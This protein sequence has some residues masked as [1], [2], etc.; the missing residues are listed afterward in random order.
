MI[1]P[2]WKRSADG[3]GVGN[4]GP[5][6]PLLAGRDLLARHE[7]RLAA[8]RRE[9]GVPA[10]HWATLYRALFEAFALYVQSLPVAT[11][12]T[13]LAA[14]L[15]AVIRS[16]ALRRACLLP[17]GAVAEEIAERQDVWTYVVASGALLRD[18]GRDVLASRVELFDGRDR[19]IGEWDPWNGPPPLASAAYARIASRAADPPRLA[20]LLSV[21]V[22]SSIVPP[23]GM[24]WITADAAALDGWLRAIAGAGAD[25]VDPLGH[26]FAP[27]PARGR[28][29]AATPVRSGPAVASP[30]TPDLGA[31]ADQLVAGLRDPRRSPAVA[32]ASTNSPFLEWLCEGLASGR[33]P[34]HGPEA[35]VHAVPDGWL[36]VAPAAFRAFAGHDACATAQKAFLRLHVHRKSPGGHHLW[37]WRHTTRDGVSRR[38]QGF[39]VPPLPGMPALAAH[40][41]EPG[42]VSLD[43]PLETVGTASD[44][45]E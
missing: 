7:E 34:T 13:L 29:D 45:V 27:V 6:M 19:P 22:A 1:T 3:S 30:A 25:P 33:V 26:L 42:L 36:I 23:P 15:D 5:R 2:W 14:R 21:L 40:D 18:L 8:I 43:G 9:V 28:D 12:G 20:A 39:V 32:P 11:G 16:L 35:F 41:P 37:N 38:L 24:C 17:R 4:S 44:K 10:A 31:I